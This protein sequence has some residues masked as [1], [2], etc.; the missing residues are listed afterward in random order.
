MLGG[1]KVDPKVEKRLERID[2]IA[3]SLRY[4]SNRAGSSVL[5]FEPNPRMGKM[6]SAADSESGIESESSFDV[7]NALGG[8]QVKGISKARQV[9]A[10]RNAL[11]SWPS[12]RIMAL[13]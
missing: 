8:A 1:D 10:L 11:L 13:K 5:V 6:S 3:L 7:S 4:G 2:A 9:M 12:R